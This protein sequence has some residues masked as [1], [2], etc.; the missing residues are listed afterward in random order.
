MAT[1]STPGMRFSRSFRSL[2]V[3]SITALPPSWDRATMK[4]GQSEEF[5]SRTIGSSA[6]SGSSALATSTRSLTRRRAVSTSVSA[7]NSAK[8]EDTFCELV[9]VILD[10]PSRP[11]SSSS[12]GRVTRDSMSLAATPGYT[13]VTKIQGCLSSGLDSRGRRI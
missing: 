5:S 9:E 10:R 8:M 13:V 1:S 11:S 3:R 12:I 6:S 7:V 2:A 4:I